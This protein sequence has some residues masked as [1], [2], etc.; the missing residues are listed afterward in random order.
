ML[1]FILIFFGIGFR[2]V[3][4]S[5]CH[6]LLHHSLPFAWEVT[7]ETAKVQDDALA[8]KVRCLRPLAS[9]LEVYHVLKWW[10]REWND[11]HSMEKNMF[12]K[13]TVKPV[14][15]IRYVFFIHATLTEKWF[16]S[17]V[18]KSTLPRFH[19]MNFTTF[20]KPCKL[21]VIPATIFY[22][23]MFFVKTPRIPMDAGY[24]SC[25]S[26]VKAP[27]ITKEEGKLWP[28]NETALQMRDKVGAAVVLEKVC[29]FFCWIEGIATLPK[30]NIALKLFYILGFGNFSGA[31]C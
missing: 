20:W 4:N 12:V 18:Y 11:P 3:G 25:W 1:G 14:H 22:P 29:F 15:F 31:N 28:H 30:F 5:R 24:C 13:G 2:V 8:E 19:R 9:F 21:L 26:F 27:L 6:H 17:I 7:M 16:E 23:N 10:K